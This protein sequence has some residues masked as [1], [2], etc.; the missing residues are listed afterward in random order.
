MLSDETGE[1]RCGLVGSALGGITGAVN[2][3]ENG[4]PD[5]FK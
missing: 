2:Q 3:G 5:M 1:L 4:T